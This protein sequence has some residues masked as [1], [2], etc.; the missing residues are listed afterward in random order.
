MIILQK[1]HAKSSL[2]IATDLCQHHD[3]IFLI[4][5]LKVSIVISAQIVNL[6]LTMSQPK[7]NN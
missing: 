7:M 2:L 1:H 4:I 5:Y 3:E 6:I